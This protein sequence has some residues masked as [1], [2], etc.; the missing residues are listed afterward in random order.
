M[1]MP[2]G[3]VRPQEEIPIPMRYYPAYVLMPSP[4][5]QYLAPYGDTHPMVNARPTS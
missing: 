5:G 2:W 4:T 1:S 3:N